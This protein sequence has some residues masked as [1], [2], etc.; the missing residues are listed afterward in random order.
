MHLVTD[1]ILL[2]KESTLPYVGLEHMESGSPDLR[3]HAMASDSIS[4]NCIFAA[5]DTLFGK[6]RPNLRK[7]VIAP[8]DGYCSTDILVLRATAASEPRFVARL[9][10]SEDVA[11]QA[12]RTAIGTKMPR[13]SWHA[14][15]KMP[16]HAPPLVEQSLIAE[17]ADRLDEAIRRTEQLGEKLKLAKQGLLHDLLTRGIDDNG[18]LRDPIRHPEQFTTIRL[19]RIPSKWRVAPLARL[20]A[21]LTG[22]TLGRH[23][24]GSGTV[25]LPYLR[26][27]NVQDGHI[28]TSD[29]RSVRVWQ[30]DVP[31]LALAPD[32]V[33]M[34]EGGDFDKLG[35]G[36]V[37]DGR[38]EPCLHQNHIFRVRCEKRLIAPAFLNI[39]S[40]SAY[41][42]RYF[43]LSSK[44]TTNLA[45]INST[46]LKAFPVPYPTLEEQARIVSTLKSVEDRLTSETSLGHKLRF[47]KQALMDDLLTGRVRVTPLLEKDSTP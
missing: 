1:K 20:A 8:F 29:I 42:K 38:I 44:Q 46:Q 41:G 37:W 9:M 32:D 18:E 21:V 19:G 27:A 12:I 40:G 30:K 11:S 14:L 15:R 3:G 28:D 34:T 5:G 24:S 4:T 43:A 7:V 26:V 13:T 2:G 36:A 39:V 10:Q 47:L 45:S 16:V 6:L 23:L 25:E 33:L 35:R 31:S 22:V 17:V